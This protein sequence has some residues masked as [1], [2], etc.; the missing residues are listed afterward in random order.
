MFPIDT[1]RELAQ[2]KH[3]GG[4]R[5][6]YFYTD[7]SVGPKALRKSDMTTH[8]LQSFIA[9]LLDGQPRELP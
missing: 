2:Q 1:V 7:E 4:S 8:R 5:L 6:L 3:A 9:K